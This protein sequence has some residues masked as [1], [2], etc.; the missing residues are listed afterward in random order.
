[1]KRFF[2]IICIVLGSLSVQAQG[3][4][5]KLLDT[6]YTDVWSRIKL[7]IHLGV[8]LGAAAPWPISDAISGNDRIRAIPHVTPTLGFSTGYIFNEEWSLNAEASYRTVGVDAT[9]VTLDKGQNF[10][11]DGEKV[12]FR[13][14]AT[15][16]ISFS[17]LEVPLYVRWDINQT[18]AVTLGLYYAYVA[19]GKFIASPIE[20]C[21]VNA[22]TP[23]A[24]PEP[25]VAGS[26]PEQNFSSS[27]SHWDIGYQ[28]GYE[29]RL[30]ERISLGGRFTMGVKDIFKPGEKYLDYSMLQMRGTLQLSYRFL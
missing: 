29:R 12:L 25:I 18:N 13:G 1:M 8:D 14:Q 26:V 9:I 23:D 6:T 16:S 20:G 7:G 15:M 21:V 11:M 24:T 22:E 27:L 10:T 17:Q 19:S 4:S 30:S 3:F 2:L 5:Q 28:I